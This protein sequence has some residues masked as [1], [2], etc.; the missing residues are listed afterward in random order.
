MQTVNENKV[1]AALRASGDTASQEKLDA[2]VCLE[3]DKEKLILE[4]ELSKKVRELTAK[5][6]VAQYRKIPR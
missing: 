6:L 2:L 3:L 1:K 4:D 5:R